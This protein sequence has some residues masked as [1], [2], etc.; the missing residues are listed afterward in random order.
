MWGLS[1][2]F[3]LAPAHH[4]LPSGIWDYLLGVYVCILEIVTPCEGMPGQFVCACTPI[5]VYICASVRVVVCLYLYIYTVSK[6][7]DV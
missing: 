3:C 6:G 7:G 5:G 2:H 4:R 1:E